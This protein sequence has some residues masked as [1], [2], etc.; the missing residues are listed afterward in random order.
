MW[1]D[2][3]AGAEV[4]GE[5]G[6]RGGQGLNSQSYLMGGGSPRWAQAE[7]DVVR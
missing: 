1:A 5:L 2:I 6:W 7:S 3:E 4:I